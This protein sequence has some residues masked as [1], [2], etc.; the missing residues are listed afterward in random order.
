MSSK[1]I[2]L[3]EKFRAAQGRP[4]AKPVDISGHAAMV[5]ATK[6]RRARQGNLMTA[7]DWRDA[8]PAIVIAD[9]QD[10]H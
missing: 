7:Q 3:F 6:E 1:S 4:V 9:L 2:A 5:K 10:R 8:E